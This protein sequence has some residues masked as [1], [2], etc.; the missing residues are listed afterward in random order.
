ME[1][2][3]LDKD[4]CI[5]KIVDDINNELESEV[6]DVE[7][8]KNHS[9]GDKG[10]ETGKIYYAKWET[11]RSSHEECLREKVLSIIDEIRFLGVNHGLEMGLTFGAENIQKDIIKR[12]LEKGFGEYTILEILDIDKKR[13]EELISNI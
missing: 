4:S 10:S 7:K 9:T 2:F 11:S 8:N 12:L 6:E 1:S 13:Y 5:K 3:N